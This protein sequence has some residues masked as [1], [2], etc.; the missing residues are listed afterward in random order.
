MTNDDWFRRTTW[1][2]EDRT[3]FFARLGRSRGASRKAQYLRIQAQT[4]ADTRRE[5]LFR[6][7]LEL[8]DRLFAESPEPSQRAA[9]HHLAATCHEALGDLEEAVHQFRLALAAAAQHRGLDPGTALEFPWFV[10]EHDLAD[11]YDE[12]LRTLAAAHLA[13]PVQFFKAAAIRAVIAARQ[14]DHR[15]AS[16]HATEALEAAGLAEAPFR[17][18]RGLGRVG[19][20]YERALERMTTLAAALP[21]REAVDP[22]RPGP[23]RARKRRAASA[24]SARPTSDRRE[25]DAP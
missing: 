19:Q 15:A 20:E 4:L 8:L 5:P 22:P 12:A 3:A 16:R 14:G 7:A 18:H 21:G 13:F 23:S 17:R 9:A 2:D 11:L 24:R 25:S 10:V 1:S 6:A